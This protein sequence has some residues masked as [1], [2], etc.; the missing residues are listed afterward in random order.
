MKSFEPKSLKLAREY[1]KIVI[2]EIINNKTNPNPIGLIQF[3]DLKN[4]IVGSPN[5]DYIRGMIEVYLEDDKWVEGV[6]ICTDI[7]DIT[8][9]YTSYTPIDL[10]DKFKLA[11]LRLSYE[12]GNP[13]RPA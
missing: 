10:K 3:L 4:L 5:R 9:Y 12:N 8:Q 13:R 1:Q 7:N 6:Y 2:N 11:I